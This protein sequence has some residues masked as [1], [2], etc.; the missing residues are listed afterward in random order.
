MNKETPNT[1]PQPPTAKKRAWSKYV[2]GALLVAII[3]SYGLDAF[4]INAAKNTAPQTASALEPGDLVYGSGQAPVKIVEYSSFTC[5][6]CKRFHEEVVPKLLAG[7]V[8]EGRADLVFRPFPLDQRAFVTS[9]AVRCLPDDDAKKTAIT[10]VFAEQGR[11]LVPQISGQEVLDWVGQGLT[12]VQKQQMTTCVTAK[13]TSEQVVA[14]MKAGKE[15]YTIPGTPTIVVGKQVFPGEA[16]I[17]EI[18]KAL[19]ENH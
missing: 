3:G 16:S 17:E 10:K 15:R 9:L 12:D 19:Q 11:L 2:I 4:K 5:P 13:E 7:P 6:H 8:K 18:E 1:P 14:A